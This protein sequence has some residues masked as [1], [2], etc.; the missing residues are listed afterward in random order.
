MGR[1]DGQVVDVDVILVFDQRFDLQEVEDG[2]AVFEINRKLDLDGRS[3]GLR[4]DV[5]QDLQGRCQRE[6]VVLEYF[7]KVHDAGALDGKV[8]GNL[9][10][11]EVIDGGGVF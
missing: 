5:Q 2:R 3:H 8:I 7:G 6:I 4:E 1:V 9:V 11:H 10:V